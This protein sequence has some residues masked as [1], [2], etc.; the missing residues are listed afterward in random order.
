MDFGRL[1]E[2]LQEILVEAVH[3]SPEL[4]R[5]IASQANLVAQPPALLAT[6]AQVVG[7]RFG[8]AAYGQKLLSAYQEIAAA[9]GGTLA[10]LNANALLAA[11]LKPERLF[12][13]RT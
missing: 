12:L 9:D 8:L 2:P 3:S 1:D 6:N 7:D 10:Y 13:L 5:E 4:A 11:F